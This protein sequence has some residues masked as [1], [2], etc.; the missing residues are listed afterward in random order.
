MHHTVRGRRR[1]SVRI[2][3]KQHRAEG[4]IEV[5]VGKRAY[6]VEIE[7]VEPGGALRAVKINHRHY[8]VEIERDANGVPTRV[9]LRG[10]PFDLAIERVEAKR[11]RPPAP[12]REVSGETRALLPGQIVDVLVREGDPVERGQPVMTLEAMKMENGIFAPKPGRIARLCV[13]RGALVRKGDLLCVV[14]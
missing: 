5:T 7:P 3:P 1:H 10:I 13:E 2:D 11:Y 9:T 12:K 8:P 4:P 14:E 6:L